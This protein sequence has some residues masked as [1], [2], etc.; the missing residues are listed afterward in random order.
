MGEPGL[1]GGGGVFGV[2]VVTMKAFASIKAH[3]VGV[4]ALKALAPIKAHGAWEYDQVLS[5]RSAA[6]WHVL[7]VAC[8]FPT[9]HLR[10]GRPQRGSTALSV[11]EANPPVKN[12]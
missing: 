7:L 3:R 11:G 6:C 2:G 12:P 9:L 1:T 8:H 5:A 10:A 4:V